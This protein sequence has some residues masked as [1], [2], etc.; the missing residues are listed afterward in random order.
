MVSEKEATEIL[1]QL[2]LGFRVL[3]KNGY[4]HRDIKPANFL[5]SKGKYKIADFGLACKADF[6]G[7]TLIKE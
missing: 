5:I 7:K 3:Y 4:I 1:K 6:K 2:L